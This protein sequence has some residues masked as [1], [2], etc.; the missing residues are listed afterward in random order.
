VKYFSA[1]LFY[2]IFEGMKNYFFIFLGA[3]ILSGCS[4][5][6]PEELERLT[7]EDPAFKQMIVARDQTRAQIQAIKSDLLGK[8]KAVDAQVDRLRQEYDNFAK[9]QNQKIEKLKT[10]IE[11][12]RNLLKRQIESESAQLAAKATELEGYEKTLTDVKKVLSEQKGIRLSAQEKQKWEERVLM[13]SEK[14]RPLTEEI[15]ELKLKIRLKKQKIQF[16]D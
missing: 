2:V 9:A 12:N 8:K 4:S 3:F 11:A 15:Q 14:M 7:K 1:R 13:L 5:V 16:L 6:S 10:G